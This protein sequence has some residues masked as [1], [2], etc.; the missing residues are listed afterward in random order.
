MSHLIGAGNGTQWRPLQTSTPRAH[1]LPLCSTK[2]LSCGVTQTVSG[3]H[4]ETAARTGLLRF[5]VGVLSGVGDKHTLDVAA[6][7]PPTTEGRVEDGILQCAYHGY[8]FNAAGA[9]IKIPHASTDDA[10]TRALASPRACAEAFPTKVVGGILY[11]W[12]DSASADQAVATE[13]LSDR[14]SEQ[15]ETQGEVL[16]VVK[17][18]MSLVPCTWVFCVIIGV[19][20]GCVYNGRCSPQ[21]PHYR[22]PIPMSCTDDYETLLENVADPGHVP[23]AHDGVQGSRAKV[24]RGLFDLASIPTD[25]LANGSTPHVLGVTLPGFSGQQTLTYDPPCRLQYT[26]PMGKLAPGKKAQFTIFAT[27]VS[28]GVSRICISI[29]A[30][31]KP[32]MLSMMSKKPRWFDHAFERYVCL[33][34]WWG[35]A[36]EYVFVSLYSC[37]VHIFVYMTYPD[38]YQQQHGCVGWGWYIPSSPGARHGGAT[39]ATW[40]HLEIVRTC[41]KSRGV[42]CVRCM[43]SHSCQEQR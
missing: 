40:C 20:M 2:S 37:K 14:F 38:I 19:Y 25:S 15:E 10:Q 30:N 6:S 32:F 41:G 18:F 1:T 12:P 26:L 42:A 28:P 31:A 8:E 34:V 9:C 7:P 13:P 27:P 3:V 21:F 17:P 5:L 35:G 24:K 22:I 4:F 16:T 11:V 29:R 39:Q 43:Y 36:G 33:C 23:F